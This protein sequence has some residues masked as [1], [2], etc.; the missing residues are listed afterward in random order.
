MTDPEP[1][2]SLQLKSTHVNESELPS[3]RCTVYDDWSVVSTVPDSLPTM[4]GALTGLDALAADNSP[5]ALALDGARTRLAI[6]AGPASNPQLADGRGQ[7]LWATLDT[8]GLDSCQVHASQAVDLGAGLFSAG[9]P[10][11]WMR[12]PN[13]VVI[14]ELG[15]AS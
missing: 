1:V 8:S 4:C 3:I 2:T 12:A 10:N 6:G 15:G 14:A 9:D 13:V 11:T 5:W 7:V